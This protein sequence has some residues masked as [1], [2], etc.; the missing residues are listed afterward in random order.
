MYP[1]RELIRLATYKV[2][3]RR[4]IARRRTDCGRAVAQLARPFSWLDQ[5]LALWRKIPP[6]AKLATVPFVALV[7]RAVLPRAK[8]LGTLLRWGP[9][10]YG[11]V[12]QF[13]GRRSPPRG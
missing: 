9:L 13:A 11:V 4:G 3:L 7:T 1:Q 6:V 10:V 5:M 8:I 2:W 12:R